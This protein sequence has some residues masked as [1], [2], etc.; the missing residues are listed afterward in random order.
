[1]GLTTLCYLEKDDRYLM[2]HRVRKAH[3]E[4]HDKWIGVGGKFEPGESPEDCVRILRRYQGQRGWQPGDY[5][6]G[7]YYRD[8]E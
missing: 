7:L 6:R 4:N 2:L 5:T 1:M 8:V 3:D